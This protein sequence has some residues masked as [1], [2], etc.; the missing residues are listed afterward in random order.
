M[1]VN[2][3][4]NPYLEHNN[5]ESLNLIRDLMEEFSQNFGTEIWYM[6]RTAVND[7]DLLGEDTLGFYKTSV[8]I[9][10]LVLN[11]DQNDRTTEIS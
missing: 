10:A 2:T 7:K 1:P 5:E 8:K 6:P 3:L 11:V 9:E 4:I